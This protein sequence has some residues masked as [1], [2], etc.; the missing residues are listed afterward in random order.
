ME[1]IIYNCAFWRP[2]VHISHLSTSCGRNKIYLIG[3]SYVLKT[4][5][6]NIIFWYGVCL[7]LAYSLPFS[8][9]SFVFP[10]R[11]W[12][13][14]SKS[15]CHYNLRITIQ[16]ILFHNPLFFKICRSHCNP[17]NFNRLNFWYFLTHP[18]QIWIETKPLFWTPSSIVQTMKNAQNPLV[19][20]KEKKK[21]LKDGC[22][23]VDV[24][25][26]PPKPL[27]QVSMVY[28]YL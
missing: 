11:P 1:I 7:I 24:D 25:L 17:H 6:S 28:S 10:S 9:L 15:D 26:I 14:A 19:P 23:M 16:F 27:L 13:F 21:F 4:R 5:L 20:V 12:Q 2:L 22:Q 18:F 3:L 8:R